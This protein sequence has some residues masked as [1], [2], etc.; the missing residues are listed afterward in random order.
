MKTVTRLF[1]FA[2]YHLENH[3]LENQD[4]MTGILTLENQ[5]EEIEIQNPKR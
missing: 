5:E 3:P 4:E 2:Y 1:D